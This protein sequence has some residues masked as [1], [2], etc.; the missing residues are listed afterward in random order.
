VA[1]DLDLS[2]IINAANCCSWVLSRRTTRKGS[3]SHC[4]LRLLGSLY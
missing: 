2:I 3:W 4:K 1:F